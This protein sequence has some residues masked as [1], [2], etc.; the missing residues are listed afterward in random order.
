MDIYGCM[1]L[2]DVAPNARKESNLDSDN[3][4]MLIVDTIAK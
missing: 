1:C 4:P 3:N 2:L